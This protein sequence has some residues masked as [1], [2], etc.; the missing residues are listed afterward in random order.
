VTR[1]GCQCL[2]LHFNAPTSL[3]LNVAFEEILQLEAWTKVGEK[4]DIILLEHKDSVKDAIKEIKRILTCSSFNIFLL[5]KIQHSNIL[6]VEF[7]GNKSKF[8]IIK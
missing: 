6:S 8:I 4:K 7:L 1:V 5:L 2:L 3:G